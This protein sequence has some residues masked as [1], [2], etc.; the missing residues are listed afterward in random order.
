MSDGHPIPP[1]LCRNCGYHFDRGSSVDGN[2]ATR[3][4]EGAIAICMGCA[5]ISIFTADLGLR[6]ITDAEMAKLQLAERLDLF[7]A[8][9]AVRAM[10]RRHPLREETKQ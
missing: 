1:S 3:A 6:P 9:H 7:M 2:N 5:Q 10:R 4:T 8:R